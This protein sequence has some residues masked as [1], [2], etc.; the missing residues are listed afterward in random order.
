MCLG[1]V[2]EKQW[3][4]C[5][6][7]HFFFFSCSTSQAAISFSCITSQAK[8][9]F[10]YHV[11]GKFLFSCITSQATMCHKIRSIPR[12]SALFGRVVM[13]T[14]KSNSGS[15]RVLWPLTCLP[16]YLTNMGLG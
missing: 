7:L 8:F 6:S 3:R 14:G 15:R 16:T 1:R 4:R 12:L 13:W 2:V 11:L 10:L 9:F 5:L